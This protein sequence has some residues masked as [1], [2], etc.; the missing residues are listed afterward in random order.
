LIFWLVGCSPSANSGPI[1][2]Q[3]GQNTAGKQ[4]ELARLAR[5]SLANYSA[6]FEIK[7]DGPTPWLYQL[8]TRRA[9]GVHEQILHIEGIDKER[10]PGDIRL[11]TDGT[12]TWMSGAGTDN[13]CVQFPNNQGMDPVFIFPET[14]LSIPD[15]Q[16]LLSYTGE[17]IV[18][19]RTSLR[20]KGSAASAGGWKDAKVNLWQDKTG[21]EM[22]GFTLQASGTDMFFGTGDG[23]INAQYAITDLRPTMI[24]PVDG[25]A[26]SVLV[27]DKASKLVRLPGIAS[28][29]IS[30]SA[31]EMIRFYQTSLGQENWTVKD[32]PSQ[33]E[34]STVLSYS[35]GAESVEIRIEANSDGG[36]KVKLI[37]LQVQ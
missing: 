37:F 5:D 29:E 3:G 13:E 33:S 8:K 25:C 10:N 36:S 34:G 15:L 23:K 11:V 14:L 28:F 26:I 17:E 22:L 21:K 24:K 1:N 32:P 31:D 7:F 4:T 35:R 9:A 30:A 6:T 12:T 18:L 2:Q 19:G 20:Y 16:S 27:P